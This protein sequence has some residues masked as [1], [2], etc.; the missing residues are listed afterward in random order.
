MTSRD[1]NV[2]MDS[3][4]RC[5]HVWF[6]GER[7]SHSHEHNVVDTAIFGRCFTCATYNLL[8]DLTRGQLTVEACLACSAKTAGHGA[9]S[10]SADAY[11]G[12]FVVIHKNS[13]NGVVTFKKVP[14]KLHGVTIF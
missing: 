12:A 6:V 2:A 9:T 4:D 1:A 8:D 5:P 11:S 10:L 13:F 14:Q 3:L 7:F